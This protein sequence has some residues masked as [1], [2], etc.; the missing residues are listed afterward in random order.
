MKVCKFTR[1]LIASMCVMLLITGALRAFAEE[2]PE[3]PEITIGERLFLETRFAQAYFS[4]PAK[5]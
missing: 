1:S 2:T 4:N 3:P 5:A